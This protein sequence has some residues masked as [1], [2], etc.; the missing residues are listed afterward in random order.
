MFF[1]K[2]TQRQKDEKTLKTLRDRQKKRLQEEL[3]VAP[4]AQPKPAGPGRSVVLAFGRFN[5]PT[6]GHAALLDYMKSIARDTRADI[7][8]YPSQTKDLRK[9]P[10]PF[11]N[12]LSFLRQLFPNVYFN[13]N[14][15]V[16]T[17]IDAFKDVH[18][19]GYRNVVVVVGSDRVADFQK[20]AQY[21][22]PSNSPKYQKDKHIPIDNYRVLAVPGERDADD[23]GVSGV[24]ASKLR[25]YAL[26]G[27]YK[28]FAAGVPTKN[29]KIAQ[30]IFRQVRVHMGLQESNY[31]IKRSTLKV[32]LQ[33]TSFNKRQEP[34]EP[35]EEDRLKVKQKTEIIQVKTRQNNDLMSAKLRDVQ[36]K[37]REDL[38][39]LNEPKVKKDH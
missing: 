16:R 26:V 12:K 30:E 17:P 15:A 31:G 14:K 11:L 27:D 28:S 3:V 36:K 22:V 6:V 8:I 35:D 1:K 2:K 24:S 38:R 4:V 18:N 39:K 29:A 13:N 7:R 32:N 9:N 19:A 21:L 34:K 33:E 37:S 5:P 23:D 10:L 25:D 20:F